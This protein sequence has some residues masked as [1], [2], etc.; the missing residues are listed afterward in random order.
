M[1]YYIISTG[2]RKSTSTLLLNALNEN[3]ERVTLKIEKVKFF[4]YITEESYVKY[5]SHIRAKGIDSEKVLKRIGLSKESLLIRLDCPT[6]T[7]YLSMRAYLLHRTDVYCSSEYTDITHSGALLSFIGIHQLLTWYTLVS[8]SLEFLT[9][10][11]LPIHRTQPELHSLCIDIKFQ[12]ERISEVSLSGERLNM[13]SEKDILLQVSQVIQKSKV[14]LIFVQDIEKD[15]GR[16]HDRYTFYGL[17]SEFHCILS[18]DNGC[19]PK[20]QKKTCYS[21]FGT[22]VIQKGEDVNALIFFMRRFGINL[23]YHHALPSPCL[24]SEV[25]RI[26]MTRYLI[27][28]NMLLPMV[29]HRDEEVRVTGGKVFEPEPSFSFDPIVT[30][31]F[32]NMYVSIVRTFNLC[33]TSRKMSNG[34]PDEKTISFGNHTYCYSEE[35]VLP[36]LL[37]KIA[38]ERK[39]TQC[40][41]EKKWLKL[42]M[43]SIIGQNMSSKK[44]TTFTS[45]HLANAITGLGRHL[46][47]FLKDVSSGFC[48]DNLNGSPTV[49][50]GDTDSLMIKL[51][52]GI[53]ET[54]SLDYEMRQDTVRRVSDVLLYYLGL[55]IEKCVLSFMPEREQ[56]NHHLELK[57]EGMS[58]SSLQYPLKKRYVYL[59]EDDNGHCALVKK[60]VAS[61]CRD[62]SPYIANTEKAA[63]DILLLGWYL[64]KADEGKWHVLSPMEV[65]QSGLFLF[66]DGIRECTSEVRQSSGGKITVFL[67]DKEFVNERHF[68]IQG[69]LIF[70]SQ[71]G[72]R[73]REYRTALL[74]EYLQFR[75]SS[76]DPIELMDEKV[77]QCEKTRNI[78]ATRTLHG[79]EEAKIGETIY[80]VQVKGETKQPWQKR[81]LSLGFQDI[82]LVIREG[83]PIDMDY[84]TNRF[85]DYFVNT[86][87]TILHILL[88][89]KL[90][91][92]RK[93]SPSRERM[94]AIP[95]YVTPFS[96]KINL[97]QPPRQT[98]PGS[99]IKSSSNGLIVTHWYCPKEFLYIKETLDFMLE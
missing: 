9:T 56:K 1:S 47:S 44:E 96:Q 94:G 80:T 81:L 13:E 92:E 18:R 32:R 42:A 76:L 25:F 82:I 23:S 89:E 74:Q 62:T 12:G 41:Q 21:G 27:E 10:K 22:T 51:P 49:V 54:D 64:C 98:I 78:N 67:R 88:G 60:G 87:K 72:Q 86:K 91:V 95:R 85:L 29:Q 8:Q 66:T 65:P 5:Q 71:Y 20:C 63:L 48:H 70:G 84:Y 99:I 3:G 17:I 7:K 30:V 2:F 33:L 97:G 4:L 90:N 55:Q 75:V 19:Q 26:A 73:E 79:M 58:I 34:I 16:L 53:D 68:I 83:L 45:P 40:L 36:C 37:G 15:F 6:W 57:L 52:F 43:V 59:N 46:I 61:V 50:Y 14:D 69:D 39:T 28:K 93:K 35:G 38:E 77:I 31:D 24:L 11:F